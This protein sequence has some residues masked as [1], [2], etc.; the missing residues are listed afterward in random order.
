M[1][2]KINISVILLAQTKAATSDAA[3]EF[4]TSICNNMSQFAGHWLQAP[5]A[6]W[7]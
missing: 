7:F 1:T 6:V 2:A 3:V 5:D 4:M